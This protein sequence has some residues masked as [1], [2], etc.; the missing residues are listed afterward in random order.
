MTQREVIAKFKPYADKLYDYVLQ[1]LRK[2]FDQY[3][4]SNDYNGETFAESIDM[5]FF[6]M[7]SDGHDYGYSIIDEFFRREMGNEYVDI[8]EN[9]A[10]DRFERPIYFSLNVMLWDVF[11]DKKLK[12][13][14]LRDV[15][16]A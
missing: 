9:F 2:D 16:Y 7:G 8:E 11:I 1:Q 14:V 13:L 10:P 6:A 4:K 5:S 12:E 15:S 3:A